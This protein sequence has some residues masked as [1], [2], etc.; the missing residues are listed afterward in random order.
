MKKFSSSGGKIFWVVISS[1][2]QHPNSLLSNY[3]IFADVES[4]EMG[5]SSAISS[6]SLLFFR[7]EKIFISRVRACLFNLDLEQISLH[8]DV[9]I[10]AHSPASMLGSV[11]SVYSV[12]DNS[13]KMLPLYKSRRKM[14]KLLHYLL[15]VFGFLM[16]WC[17][18]TMIILYIQDAVRSWIHFNF[19]A[20]SSKLLYM[21]PPVP[22]DLAFPYSPSLA[23]L[24]IF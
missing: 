24:Y 16:V 19:L 17:M 18:L 1:F 20:F 10:K 8:S 6:P 5:S 23:P 9:Y 12:W 22:F 11:D 15:L 21:L 7:G 3:D 14:R 4:H 2:C 13:H